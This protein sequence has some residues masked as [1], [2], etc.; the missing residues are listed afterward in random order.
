MLVPAV[1]DFQGDT[2]W[3][4]LELLSVTHRGDVYP[5]YVLFMIPAYILEETWGLF[6]SQE[7]A[8]TGKTFSLHQHG[9]HYS[10]FFV[11]ISTH[12]KGA[13]DVVYLSGEAD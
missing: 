12:R 6:V 8:N 1:L 13:L 7:L 11:Q 3:R 5:L 2:V 10:C 9:G 4:G